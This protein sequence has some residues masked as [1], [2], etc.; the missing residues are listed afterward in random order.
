MKYTNND[1]TLYIPVKNSEK[2][3]ER[4]IISVLEQKKVPSLILVIDSDSTDRTRKIAKKHGIRVVK[5]KKQGLASARNL[6]LSLCKTKLIASIDSDCVLSKEW[7]EKIIESFSLN[8][9]NG[10]C[11]SM[12]EKYTKS[13]ADKWRSIHLPQTLGNKTIKNPDFL[14]GSNSIYVADD[15][16]KIGGYN[17]KYTTNYEDVDISKRLKQTG[18]T[19]LY[20]PSAKCI[21]L[22]QDTIRS[23][24]KAAKR[25]H[26]YSFPLPKTVLNY[27]KRVFMYNPYHYIKESQRDILNLSVKTSALTFLYFLYLQYDDT[28]TYIKSAF[29][30]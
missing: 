3:I 14:F 25:W 29:R 20:E 11:G 17:D 16:R 1:V 18:K 19:I 2:T 24:I 5:N 30:R 26:H 23:V 8:D 22:K 4:C 7:L 15:L 10:V 12:P 21:H 28:R 27:L 13:I 6:A 9:V